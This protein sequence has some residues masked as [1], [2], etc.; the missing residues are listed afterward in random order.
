MSDYEFTRD[1]FSSKIA[2]WE[3]ILK[4]L[5]D[6]FGNDL[7]C[8]EVG[9]CEGRSTVYMLDNFIGNG[10]LTSID[11]FLNNNIKKRFFNNMLKHPKRGQLK[12][13]VGLSLIE[14]S[15]LYENS[16]EFHFIYIDA[17][18]TAS[19]NCVNLIIAEK[20]CKIGGIILVDD[21]QYNN[22]SDPKHCPKL[23]INSFN[24]ITLN[25]EIFMDNYQIAFK[26]IKNTV[27]LEKHY[28]ANYG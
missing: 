4:Y 2:N 16:R 6:K 21:Y 1:H 22:D 26:K 25:C 10:T 3:I 18:K 13:H 15:K 7:D 5:Q 17:G 27:E 24:N 12:A 19:D 8:L 9:S 28:G 23:G 20:L 11:I 14:M